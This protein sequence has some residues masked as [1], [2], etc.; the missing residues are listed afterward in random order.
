M[1]R[2][3][4]GLMLVISFSQCATE[5]KN[6]I[7][8]GT[9]QGLKKGQLLIQELNDTVLVTLDSIAVQG[10]ADFK[11]S[12][13]VQEPEVLYLALIFQD[14]VTPTKYIPFFAERGAVNIQTDLEN[15][16]LDY[17]VSGSQNQTVWNEYRQLMRRYNEK[18]LD[19]IKE[20]LS[21]MQSGNTSETENWRTQ[22]QKLMT[23][24]YL[25]TV[26]FAKN[27]RDMAIAPYLMLLEIPDVNVKYHDTIYKLLS[28]EIKNSKYGNALESFILEQN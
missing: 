1:K 5:T 15:F 7:I 28:P 19:Y 18:K 17:A 11:F 21:A 6:T 25:A 4:F 27:H 8:S 23:S 12:V 24:R 20:E 9:V 13:D 2:I 16:E 10:N 14:S 3:I 26:N 22:Q